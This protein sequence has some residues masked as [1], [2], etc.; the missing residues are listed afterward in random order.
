MLDR[1][2]LWRSRLV[3]LL[4]RVN[5][6]LDATLMWEHPPVSVRVD[7]EWGEDEWDP[8]WT[9]SVEDSE[10]GTIEDICKCPSQK[11]VIEETEAYL[12]KNYPFLRDWIEPP[13][14]FWEK[15]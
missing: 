7:E 5:P 1:R 11:V 8:Y 3:D 15:L 2:P 10:K 14:T 13:C 6:P 12:L 9:A 4:E